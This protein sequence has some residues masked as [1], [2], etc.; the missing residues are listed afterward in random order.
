MKLPAVVATQWKAPN[1]NAG[2]V[3]A[4]L[5]ASETQ[6][7]KV[8]IPL[9]PL[10]LGFAADETLNVYRVDI[11]GTTEIGSLNGGGA[12]ISLHGRDIVLLEIRP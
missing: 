5:E 7:R 9:A 12:Q 3:V 2:V 4:A 8:Y 6:Q 10:A 11:H 1:G